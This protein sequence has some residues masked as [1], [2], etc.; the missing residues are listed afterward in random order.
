MRF[1]EFFLNKSNSYN[2]YKDNYYS[3]SDDKRKLKKNISQLKKQNKIS[4]NDLKNKKKDVSFLKSELKNKNDNI[5]FLKSELKT[6]NDNISFLK[7]DLDNKKELVSSLENENLVLKESLEKFEREVELLEKRLESK[8]DQFLKINKDIKD[9]N[10]AYVIDGF[11][12]HSETFIVNEIR[13]LVNNGFNIKVF[14]NHESYKPVEI[15]FFAENYR[16]N[17]LLELEELLIEHDIEFMHTHFV[18]HI[19]TQFTHPVAEK[20][21]I[22]FS[23]FAHA[24]DIFRDVNVERNNVRAISKSKYCVAIFTLSNYHKDFLINHGVEEDKIVIT[25]QAS[26]YELSDMEIKDKPIKRIVSISRFVEKKGIGDLIDAAKILEDEDYE[27]EI[28]GFGDLENQL[29]EKIDNLD[30]K[31]ISI[32]GELTPSEVQNVLKESDLLVS[33]CK[34]AKNGDRDGFPTVIFEAMAT[35]LAVLTTNVSA[36]PEVIEDGVNGFIV[37]PNDPNALVDKIKEISNMSSEELF[38]IRKKAQDD[39]INVSSVEKTMNTFFDT[40]TNNV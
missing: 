29:Q 19:C 33:P 36:I 18:Y 7:S 25:K 34:I 39:V 13:W 26:D 32:K 6:K 22:P 20:L 5:S 27:F 4:S 2:F 11:P 9:L 40:I 1:G 35:G 3:L 21:K 14:T 37:E 31:N 30:S 23:V 38:E 15:D 28:Y 24:V 8:S 12:I 10:I 16:F 17:D